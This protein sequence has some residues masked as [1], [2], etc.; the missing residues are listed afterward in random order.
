MLHYVPPCTLANVPPPPRVD[1]RK[2][3]SFFIYDTSLYGC[4]IRKMSQSLI[5][6]DSFGEKYEIFKNS[7]FTLWVTITYLST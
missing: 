6:Q 7:K 3:I 4:Q 1:I 5:V 2:Y